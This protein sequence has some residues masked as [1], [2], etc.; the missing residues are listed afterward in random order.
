MRGTVV[1]SS[2]RWAVAAG[3][4]GVLAVLTVCLTV[5]DRL[6]NGEQGEL[7]AES[8]S[9]TGAWVVR[10]Y[11]VDPGAAGSAAIRAEVVDEKKQS[12]QLYIAPG[13]VAD[14]V[15][16]SKDVVSINGHSLDV[17]TDS[18]PE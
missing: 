10:A 2:R 18:Y 1:A 12:R 6:W 15:W 3:I 5:G 4:I 7:I 17:R 11:Y 9:P 13:H 14:I 16:E 8:T